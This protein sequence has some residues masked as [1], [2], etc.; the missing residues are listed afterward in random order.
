MTDRTRDTRRR[1][2]WLGLEWVP[3]DD[4]RL[5]SMA[6]SLCDLAQGLVG[7]LS[8]GFVRADWTL[9]F[10]FWETKRRARKHKRVPVPDGGDGR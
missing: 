4:G 7:L 1:R 5:R 9:R 2:T 6:Y 8:L 3:A 10:A